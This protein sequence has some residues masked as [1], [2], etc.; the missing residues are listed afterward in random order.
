[1]TLYA[2]VGISKQHFTIR[3]DDIGRAVRDAGHRQ[4]DL[5]IFDHWLGRD[6]N[7][8]FVAACFNRKTLQRIDIVC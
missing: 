4:A 1:M 5:V 2:K 8:E 7:G 6:A 3:R